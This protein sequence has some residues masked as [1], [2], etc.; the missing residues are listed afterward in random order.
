MNTISARGLVL[1][2]L[3]IMIAAASTVADGPVSRQNTVSLAEHRAYLDAGVTQPPNSHILYELPGQTDVRVYTVTYSDSWGEMDI[4]YPG[5]FDYDQPLPAVLMMPG[6]SDSAV[7]G[8]HGVSWRQW[9]R[10]GEWASLVAASGLAAVLWESGQPYFS[11]RDAMSFLNDNGSDL[12]IDSES[13]GILTFEAQALTALQLLSHGE[14]PGVSGIQ[15]V[16]MLYPKDQ[17]SYLPAFTPSFCIVRAG[18]EFR[19]RLEELDRYVDRLRAHGYE[20]TVVDYQEA[21]HHFDL[22]LDTP[23]TRE[24]IQLVLDFLVSELR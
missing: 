23:R 1:T 22:N 12:M 13:L 17:R 19:Q 3:L 14:T 18:G 9:T 4:Y 15:A 16:A 20:T 7:R 8:V 5:G 11:A 6:Y 2:V 24:I 10:S 21:F